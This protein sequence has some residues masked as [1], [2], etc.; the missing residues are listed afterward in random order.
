MV[1]VETSVCEEVVFSLNYR[2]IRAL[3]ASCH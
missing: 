2:E 1:G 3:A